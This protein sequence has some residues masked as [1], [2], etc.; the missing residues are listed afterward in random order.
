MQDGAEIAQARCPQ[1]EWWFG[2][3]KIRSCIFMDGSSCGVE[4]WEKEASQGRYLSP[5]YDY[6]RLERHSITA[7][8]AYQLPSC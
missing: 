1:N 3:M 2:P 6:G 7:S 4:G 5:R 8:Q